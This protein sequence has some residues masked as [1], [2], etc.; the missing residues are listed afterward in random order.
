MITVG[1]YATADLLRFL[2]FKKWKSKTSRGLGN[3]AK[4]I[5]GTD[6]THPVDM[7]FEGPKNVLHWIFLVFCFLILR[8]LRLRAARWPDCHHCYYPWYSFIQSWQL[9]LLNLKVL[10]QAN[11]LIYSATSSICKTKEITKI[12]KIYI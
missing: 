12:Y 9:T 4:I 8:C 6:M 11:K 2:N 5:N 1:N 7:S 3:D 10:I